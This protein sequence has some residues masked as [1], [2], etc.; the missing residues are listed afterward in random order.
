[1]CGTKGLVVT[2]KVHP[3]GDYAHRQPFAYDPIRRACAPQIVVTE[4]FDAA[5]VI[6]LAHTKDLICHAEAL[7]PRLAAHQRL[8]L[9]SEEPLWDCVWA[10]DPLSRE[11]VFE[12][13]T[14][15]VPFVFL[16][17]VTSDIYAF[18]R[19]PYFLLTDYAYPTRYSCWFKENAALSEADWAARFAATKWDLAFVAEYRD[20]PRFDAAFPEAEF[21]GLGRWRTRLALACTGER[22]LRMGA[23]WNLLPRRQALPDWHL[24]KYLDLRDRC[25]VLSAVENTYHRSYVT[26][27]VFD[28]LAIG[29]MPL[30]LAG[31]GHRLHDLLPQGAFVNLHGM[32]PEVAAERIMGYRPDP[33][34]L[35]AYCEAQA[36]LSA[37]FN[38]PALLCAEYDRLAQAL[39]RNLSDLV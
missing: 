10:A 12:T 16:N 28:S 14:G 2:I 30:Y 39:L 26:E 23:G 15:Q 34:I 29:A 11:Q 4:A 13:D 24:E 22:L 31:P 3:F 38:T 25:A 19:I 18:E 5:D 36:R 33:Q 35:S 27:K 20:E 37:L 1:L 17:H 6:L 8:V 9:L 7:R 21:Y 32:T